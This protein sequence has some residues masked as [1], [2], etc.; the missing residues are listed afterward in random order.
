ME[1]TILNTGAKMPLEGIGAFMM[2]PDEVQNAVTSALN[3]GYELVDTANAYMNEKAV[4]RGIKA[5][6]KERSEVFLVSK[7]I[8]L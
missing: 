4:G 6:E 7:S 1:Y 2:A 3:N 5:S 8:S